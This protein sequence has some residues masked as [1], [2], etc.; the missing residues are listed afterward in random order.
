M[1]H[2]KRYEATIQLGATTETDDPESRP[3]ATPGAIAPPEPLLREALEQFVGDIL[4]TPPAYSAIKLSGRRACD[5]I[6]AGEMVQ[7]KP[8]LIHVDE[9]TLLEYAWPLAKVR[10][11][12]GR[13]TYVRAIARDLGMALKVGAHLTQ[14]RRTRSG[15]FDVEQA[16]TIE[17]LPADGV[18]PHLI[19][20]ESSVS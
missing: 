11:N 15:R 14:L 18:E 7:L 13:G 12:C 3:H 16:F 6:R 4:Q 17:Q 2:P 1:N 19:A 5:R 10:I 20:L 9:I 8:R